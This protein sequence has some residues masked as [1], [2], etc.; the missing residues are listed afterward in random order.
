MEKPKR[1]SSHVL[2][3]IFGLMAI[4]FLI[5]LALF[6]LLSVNLSIQS[7]KDFNS[8][9]LV[10][11]HAPLNHDRVE[12]GSA[13]LVHATARQG[14]GGVHQVEL[15]V[16]DTLVASR[17]APEGTTPA[18]MVLS[19]SWLPAVPGSHVLIVR[20]TSADGVQ[21]QAAVTV[22]VTEGD[23]EAATG[24]YLVEEGDT[25]A[26]I[27]E[28][29]STI[30][31]DL[32]ELNPEIEDG[33]P[34]AG[35]ELTVPDVEEGSPDGEGE[36]G[37]SEEGGIED[38]SD[39]AEAAPEPEDD[40]PGGLDLSGLVFEFFGTFM[41]PSAP[42]EP[43]GLK[44]EGLL[45]R[46]W[47]GEES[48]HCFISLANQPPRWVPDAD[49]NPSTDETFPSLER[50]WWDVQPYLA[51]EAAPVIYWPDNRDLTF[52]ASCV[53]V[54]AGGTD[55]LELGT[56]DL[57]I[58]PEKWD[59][60]A[61]HAEV[62]GA[63]GHL[64][65]QYRVSRQAADPRAFPLFLDPGMTPPTNVRLDERRNS[66]RWD[67]SP[68][69]DEEAIT[70]F[71]IYLNGNLQWVEDASTLESGLPY[72]WFNPPCG[73][74]Y[75]F[76][77][78]AYRY[79][80]PDGPESPS[81][82]V[83]ITT[84]AEGCQREIQ[85]NLISLETLDL[86]GD[87]R[88]EDRGGD[89]GPP[90]GSFFANEWQVSFDTRVTSGGG[91]SLDVPIG[92]TH[93][94]LYNIGSISADPAWRF[95]GVP[96]T[97]VGI[98]PGGSFEFGFRILDDD[99]GRCHNSD[100]PGCD[101]LVCE[102]QSF[103]YQDSS[104]GELDRNHE[105]VLTSE[106]ER[107]RLTYTFG[108]AFSSPV[109]SGVPGWEPMPWIDVEDVLIDPVSGKMQIPII[110]SGTATWPWHDLEVE[111]QTRS[112]ES[113]GVYTWEN[114][115]L[116]AGQG[117][118]LE[119]PDI[120]L[121]APYDACV[122]IDPNNLVMEQ[123]EAHDIL[124][125]N[126]VCPVLP[127][128]VIDDVHFD[129]A[130]GGQLFVTVTN[131]GE[132]RLDNR[133][134]KLQ[135]LLPDGSPAYLFSSWPNVSLNPNESRIFELSAVNESMRSRLENGYTMYVDPDLIIPESSEE[136]NSY[137]IMA[138]A[139]LKVWWCDS[140]IP[141]YHGLGSATRLHLKV[142]VVRGSA[143]ETVYEANRS[144]TLTSMETYAYEYNHCYQQGCNF[145]LSCD[146]S[147]PVF[148]VAGDEALRVS[149]RGEFRA[150]SYGDF[151]SL[152]S[153]SQT[154]RAAQNWGA[155]PAEDES[156]WGFD[157]SRRISVVPGLG[158]LNPEPWWSEVCILEVP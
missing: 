90:Y 69:P 86:G 107:C 119:H 63:E 97:V 141:H 112:G 31:E 128:L 72:E 113:L 123:Y 43:V 45:L 146:V 101:D 33:E 64:Y 95:S 34:A 152:G 125:H 121:E 153:G 21:G 106:D 39:E 91:G 156:D 108:P 6:A 149:V 55:A 18:S 94:T 53:G 78:T 2:W 32:A 85:I 3:I 92:L 71:R 143:A 102:G 144:N 151:E 76:A 1:K 150:G 27:A 4:F 88:Y 79:E 25:L 98:P 47:G 60:S 84:P 131:T 70:G 50:G 105:G 16:D 13:V 145:S 44:L 118:V 93:N 38:V 58:P 59:G 49:G 103:I 139:Q 40:P 136:N 110:N 29:H 147:S 99:T 5:L 8:R 116:E 11:I 65:L 81:G 61:Q 12:T 68:R 82:E 57:S 9:P 80:L 46:S 89:V 132:A 41:S 129:A 20:A 135:V 122:L 7:K 23:Q 111:I 134:L 36:A 67:Y 74:T 96:Y 130:G 120:L 77:V 83:S 115:V 51:G 114:Y 19:E 124:Y 138:S 100:D 140:Y 155:F 24:T 17:Q 30:S 66:L 154:W 62:V 158:M 127:D 56:F 73:A 22:L 54:A 14:T 148:R 15:W 35:D 104:T 142:E 28:E 117:A 87:G 37:I 133:T 126:P 52:T 157:S 75:N 26:S 137:D 48:M 10:L 109:G 42:V